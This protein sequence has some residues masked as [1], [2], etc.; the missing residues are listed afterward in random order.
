MHSLGPAPNGK[1]AYCGL[2][3]FS[4]SV[5]LSGMNFSGS[6]QYSGSLCIPYTGITT[7]SPFLRVKSE[8]GNLYGFTA[9][10]VK[11]GTGGYFRKASIK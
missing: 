11:L 1:Y 10:L 3:R 4:S 8:L 6:G 5:N 9:F 2:W 7:W